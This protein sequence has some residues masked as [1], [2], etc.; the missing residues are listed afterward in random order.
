MIFGALIDDSL[1]DTISITVLATGFADNTKQNLD[2]LNDVV[3]GKNMKSKEKA[4]SARS[5]SKPVYVE[6][7]EEEE[8][9]EEEE[10]QGDGRVPSFLRTLKRRR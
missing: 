1:E 8:E 10:D 4:R 3:S 5:A 7:V 6:E 2:F 9:E